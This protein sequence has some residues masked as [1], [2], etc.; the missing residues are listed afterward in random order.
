M[1]NQPDY[2]DSSVLRKIIEGVLLAA[3]RSMD[4]SHIESLFEEGEKPPRDHIR[5][6]LE[7]IEADCKG[8]GFELKKTASG[9]RFQVRQELAAWVNRLW[10]EKPKRYSRAMLETLSLIA[11][12]QPI[13][14]GDIEQIRGVSVSSDIIKTLMEREWIRI[15]GHRDVPGRPALYSTTRQFLD[16]FNLNTLDELPSLSEL[17]DFEELDPELELD[18]VDTVEGE[19][20]AEATLEPIA[21]ESDAPCGDKPVEQNINQDPL[22][23][24]ALTPRVDAH[25]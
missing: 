22:L 7:E 11:Y 4:I 16:Y 21:V 1:E 25:E 10:D 5:A 19:K 15:V 3:G 17:K 2:I 14:R 23:D 20:N 6:A 12:R 9:Y 8:R 24:Q 18:V 13:T